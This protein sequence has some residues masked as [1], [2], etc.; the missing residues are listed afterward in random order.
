MGN[1][2]WIRPIAIIFLIELLALHFIDGFLYSGVIK[3]ELFDIAILLLLFCF[4]FIKV[5]GKVKAAGLIGLQV[6]IL[7]L[8]IFNLPSATYEGGKA[9]VQNEISNEDVT[10]V[11][12]NYKLIPAAPR[13]S[14][15]IDD[16]YYH[17]E[18]NVSG[19]TLFYVVSPV[20]GHSFQL[21]EDFFRYER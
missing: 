7:F 1:T 21:K 20:D 5:S 19:E 8:F 13:K 12:T 11:S 2:K 17:Y 14:W 16:V 9:I 10:F 18:V 15:F 3:T 6:L 4:L